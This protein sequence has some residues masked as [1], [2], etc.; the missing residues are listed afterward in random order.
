MLLRPRQEVLVD[1]SLKALKERNQTLAVAPTG[2]G[3]TV[4]LSAITGRVLG[5]RSTGLVIQHR[6]ELVDQNRKTYHRFWPQANTGVIDAGH[7]EWQ[8]QVVFAMI[9]TLARNLKAMRPVDYIAIDEAHHAAAN[10]YVDTI[11]HARNLNPKLQ[12]LGVTATPNRGD[13]KGLRSVFDNVSDQ[14]TLGELIAGGFLVRPRTFVV[15]LGVRDELQAVRKSLADFDMDAVASI[16][17]KEV[18][19]EAVIRH[20][21]EKAGGRRT[22]VFCSTIAHAGHVLEAFR[23]AGVTAGLITG[24]MPGGERAA[25]LAAFDRGQLQVLVNVMVLTEGWDCP[26]VSC[27]ILL[28]PSSYKSTM[29][30]MVG[31]GLRTIDP[32]RYPGEIKSDCIVLDFGTST[33]LHGSLEQDVQLDDPPKKGESPTMVC[34]SCGA[35]IPINSKECAICGFVIPEPIE[36]TPEDELGLGAERDK[37]SDFAMTEIDLF[38]SSPF[39]WEDLFGDAST[40][41]ASGFEAWAIAIFFEGQWYGLG[42]ATGKSITIVAV[43][44]RMLCIAA[45]DDWMRANADAD[46]AGKSRRWLNA[47]PSDRQLEILKTT[48]ATAITTG[49]TRYTAACRLTWKFNENGIRSKLMG[50]SKARIAA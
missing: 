27:V 2:A 35:H 42:G 9:Q 15:D 4:M 34:E 46:A 3:K 43:G 36:L 45:C 29:I 50:Q 25:T 39:K 16:M 10:S 13:K 1:R 28:R 26:P 12:L 37:M 47:A 8:R 32:E 31:R 20:W 19:N 24:E 40:L 44:E 49:V 21:R 14:I 38:N 11:G 7:K 23:A 48:R 5:P 22:V 30:Q 41:V 6:D 17:D 33:L 18:L